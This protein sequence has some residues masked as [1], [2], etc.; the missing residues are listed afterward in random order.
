MLKT[1]RY[2]VMVLFNI[3]NGYTVFAD[4][5]GITPCTS[6][7]FYMMESY[8]HEKVIA[9]NY[10]MHIVEVGRTHKEFGVRN[11]TQKMY[12]EERH[13]FEYL[14]EGANEKGSAEVTYTIF[15]E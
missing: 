12:Y 13:V 11:E 5:I 1:N 14:I 15:A 9:A 7:A 6:D 8:D 2:V 4:L 3:D 10:K